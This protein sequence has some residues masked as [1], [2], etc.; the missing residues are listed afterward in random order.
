M[1][2]LRCE[3]TDESVVLP[4]CLVQR[5]RKFLL[6]T[7]KLCRCD[8][9]GLEDSLCRRVI[10]TRDETIIKELDPEA[11]ASSRDAL[12]KIVYSRMFDWLACL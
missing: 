12:A 6:K 4:R 1:I 5:I 11:A 2:T 9:K 3:L 7:S 8:A 10:V